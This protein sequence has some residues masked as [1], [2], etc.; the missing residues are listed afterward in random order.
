MTDPGRQIAVTEAVSRGSEVLAKSS[1]RLL[2]VARQQPF[3]QV[4]KSLRVACCGDESIAGFEY[5][6]RNVSAQ[7]TRAAGD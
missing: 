7:T 1:L 3:Y 4:I 2:A 6:P 5:G